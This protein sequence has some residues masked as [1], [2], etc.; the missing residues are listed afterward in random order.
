M[1]FNHMA[2]ISLCSFRLRLG[3]FRLSQ[4][5]SKKRRGDCQACDL[6]SMD[7]KDGEELVTFQSLWEKTILACRMKYKLVYEHVIQIFSMCE[8]SDMFK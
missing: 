5:D 1:G 6:L 7:L 8:N 4:L 3:F 2:I